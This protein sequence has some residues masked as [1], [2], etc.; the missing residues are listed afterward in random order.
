MLI[1]FA[2]DTKICNITDNT[3]ILQDELHELY[4]WSHKWLPPFTLTCSILHYPKHY[5]NYNYCLNKYMI[6]IDCF[7]KDL[8]VIF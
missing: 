8:C 6:N 1:F 4:E 2:D 5:N 3:T 7:I